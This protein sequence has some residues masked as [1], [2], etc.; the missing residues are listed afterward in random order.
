ME[1]VFITKYNRTGT[2]LTND[3]I[4]YKGLA[5]RP[6]EV[7]LVALDDPLDKIPALIEYRDIR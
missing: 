5:K 6:V 2:V 3:L 7:A 4:G 1:K